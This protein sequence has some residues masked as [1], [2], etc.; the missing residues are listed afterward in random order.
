MRARRE[1]QHDIME[2]RDEQAAIRAYQLQNLAQRECYVRRFRD[3]ARMDRI[4]HIG[5]TREIRLAATRREVEGLKDRL[6]R[7]RGVP[8]TK[9]KE[10]INGRKL[11]A[12]KGARKPDFV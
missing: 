9:A 2:N 3:E 5:K 1:G 7:E 12:Q 6:M 10:I 4:I 11:S 8:L